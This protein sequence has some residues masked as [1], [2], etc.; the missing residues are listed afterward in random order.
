MDTFSDLFAL[1]ETMVFWLQLRSTWWQIAILIFG[2]ALAFWIGS[3]IQKR[4]HRPVAEQTLDFSGTAMRTGALAVVPFILWV[5]LLLAS[6]ILR[7]WRHAPTDLL[8]Y[9]L[10]LVGA[11]VV[12]RVGVFVLRLS[13]SPG[14]KLQ[15]WEGLLT[16]TI[17]SIVALH[18]LGWLPEVSAVLD[19][20][21]VTLGKVR[22]SAFTVVSFLISIGLFT[23]LSLWLANAIRA[24]LHRSQNLTLSMK[25]ALAKVTKFL[26]LTAAVLVAIALAGIDLTALTVF[27][28]A[29]GVGLGLGLQR[30]VANFISGF[31]IVFEESIRPG[32]VISVGAT[33]GVVRSLDARHIVVRNSDGMD[34]LIPNEEL[35]TSQITNWSYDEDRNVRLRLPLQ[36]AYGSDPAAAMHLLTHT[37]LMHTRVLR[38]PAPAAYILGF[39]EH[40]IQLELT[41]WIGDPEQGL[42]Q[43]RSDIYLSVWRALAEAGIKLAHA[44]STSPK[45]TA[46]APLPP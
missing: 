37:A 32:D 6:A 33:T 1:Q 42:Q 15:A 26:L 43:A 40:G 20:Y 27:G 25:I 11:L 36:I 24:R 45:R 31:I 10:L 7:Y 19:E 41:V 2:V 22:I 9:A 13:F 17:W 39:G 3:E 35:I 18:I 44:D 30:I 8:H 23:L 29:L 34:V 5:W 46:G 4:M 16:F 14:G 21:S 28:G 38:E 12:I